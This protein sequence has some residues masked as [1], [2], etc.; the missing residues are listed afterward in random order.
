MNLGERLIR[1]IKL[2]RW[3]L[4]VHLL[5]MDPLDPSNFQEERNQDPLIKASIRPLKTAR[6]YQLA[7]LPISAISSAS[8]FSKSSKLLLDAETDP[9]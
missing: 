3:V 1:L 4:T 8:R 9:G 5:A 7:P 2:T 6:V